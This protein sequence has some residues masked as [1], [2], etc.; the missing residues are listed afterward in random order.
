MA[1]HHYLLQGLLYSVALH[2][3]LR[4]RQRD[5]RPEVHLGGVAYLFVRGMTGPFV[6]HD[7]GRPYGVFAWLPP[8]ALITELSDLLARGLDR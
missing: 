2:R 8:P 1:S 6:L 4:W 3:Y 7:A 5:Y